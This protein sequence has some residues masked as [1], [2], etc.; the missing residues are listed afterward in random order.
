MRKKRYCYNLFQLTKYTVS[1]KLER[2]TLS[3]GTKLFR[4]CF[5][6]NKNNLFLLFNVTI[7]IILHEKLLVTFAIFQATEVIFNKPLTL[8]VFV[9][10]YFF[11]PPI[12]SVMNIQRNNGY[13]N[14]LQV[15]L[16][17]LILGTVLFIGFLILFG[18]SLWFARIIAF[19]IW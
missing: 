2:N 15:T 10:F 6:H 13:N 19:T 1:F 4:D 16:F 9:D 14:H 3:I 17:S 7:F 11:Q 5:C 12:K 8:L 18:A